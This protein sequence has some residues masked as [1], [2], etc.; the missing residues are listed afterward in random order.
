MMTVTA[1][2]SLEVQLLAALVGAATLAF[3]HAHAETP[4]TSSETPMVVGNT[5]TVAADGW[6][7]FQSSETFESLCSGTFECTVPDGTYI[8]INHSTQQRWENVLVGTQSSQPVSGIAVVSGATINFPDDGWYQVQDTTAYE[9]ACNGLSVCTVPAGEYNIINHTNSQRWDSVLISDKNVYSALLLPDNGWYQV[10]NTEDYASVCEGVKVCEVSDGTYNIINHSNGQRMDGVQVGEPVPDMPDMPDMPAP[11]PLTLSAANAREIAGQVISVINEDQIDAFFENAGDDLEFQ[12]RQFFLS[13]TVDDI[14]FFQ[15]IDLDEPYQL[16]TNFGSGTFT[17]VPVRSEYT[18]A[19]GGTIYNYFSDRVFNDCAVGSNTYN[20][21]S[22]RRNDNLR[23]VIRSYPFWNFSATD[24]ANMTSTLTGG[25]DTGNQSFVVLNQT[26]RW[27]DASFTTTLADGVFTLSEFNIERL[28]KSDVGTSFN[29]MTSV[30]DGVRYTIR[31][32]SRSS[33]I[34]GSFNVAAGW[35][36]QETLAVNVT[37]TFSDTIRELV[38]DTLTGFPGTLDP[39]DPF[40]W[41]AGSIEITAADGSSITMVPTSPG[42]QSFSVIL[43]NGESITPLLWSDGFY[44]DCGSG[45]VC[46][47]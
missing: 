39:I 27:N 29:N 14:V 28:D 5:I 20:G 3:S 16:E 8:V 31:N 23:G 34:N 13:N 40:E 15:G 42:S 32:N 7:Q 25:F 21:T 18:C 22:G 26:Q 41:Q 12:G 9:S 35:T 30:I 24:A 36:N 1:L 19:A 47:G 6:Y 43:S 11:S 4:A 38:G 44:V 37:L 17:D 45:D 46:D 10:Q 33:T 2:K